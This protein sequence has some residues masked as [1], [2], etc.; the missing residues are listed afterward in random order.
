MSVYGNLILEGYFSNQEVIGRDKEDREYS[1]KKPDSRKD[2][3]KKTE[4]EKQYDKW[5]KER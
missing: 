1:Y 4:D 3:V 5:E 2:S